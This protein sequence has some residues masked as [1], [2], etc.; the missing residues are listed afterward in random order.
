[1]KQTVLTALVSLAS[2]ISTTVNAQP[3]LTA[4]TSNPLAGDIF[5][6]HDVDVTGL[7]KG[8][9]GAGVSWSF[10]TLTV[11][12][13]DTTSYLACSAT[14]YC[15]SFAGSNIVSYDNTDYIYGITSS[16][17]LK[18]IGGHIGGSIEHFTKPQTYINY[19]FTYN[20]IHKDTSSAFLPS[21]GAYFV[22][23]DSA[24]ADAYGTLTLPS[25]TFTNVLRVHV[26]SVEKDSFNVMGMPIVTESQTETYSWYAAGF[27]NPLLSMTYD[28]SGTGSPA[29]SDARYFTRNHPTAVSNVANAGSTIQVYPN[30]ASDKIT[31]SCNLA[32]A[33]KAVI[34]L[35]DLTGRIVAS[36]NAEELTEGANTVNIPVNNL[37]NGIYVVNLRTATGST[38]QKVVVS[39]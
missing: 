39:K 27:H 15:D 32:D 6:G 9:A 33:K 14:P 29:L 22:V 10:P 38:T 3:T 16:S 1:M 37:A 11:I 23:T 28:T 35:S 19:P 4:A 24:I 20:S 31:I 7:A 8:A 26:T 21:L 5:Y 30:P 13:V 2:V 36:I 25:G 12:N 17:A 34:T 18:F